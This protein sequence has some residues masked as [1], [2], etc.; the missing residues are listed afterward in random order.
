MVKVKF[1]AMQTTTEMQGVKVSGFAIF[2]VLR[3]E[4][5]PFRYY[6][7]MQ[8]TGEGMAEDNLKGMTEALMRKHVATTPLTDVLRDR[9]ALR[10]TVRDEMMATTKGWG[11]WPE[12]LEITDVQIC[13]NKLFEDLQAEFRQDAHVKAEQMR[14]TSSKL[15]AEQR[16]AHDEELAAL[17]CKTAL[18][19]N[20]AEIDEKTSREKYEGDAQLARAV[21]QALLAK[22]QL[23]VEEQKMETEQALELGKYKLRHALQ[24]YNEDLQRQRSAAEHAHRLTLRK[25]ELEVD[26]NMSEKALHMHNLK[27]TAQIYEKLPLKEL[28]VHNFVA[29]DSVSGGGLAA[30]LPGVHALS[31]A[32][33]EEH[34]LLA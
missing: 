26:N 33:R 18:A 17:N 5:G 12:T 14:L 15:L 32:A 31:Q 34:V 10:Q 30:L 6:K 29:P 22:K 4:D 7:Y 24:S 23:E 28:K 21:Q 20:R 3:T 16:A 25:A 2:S 19:K 1:E 11:V 27:R 8:G 9:E 13:S